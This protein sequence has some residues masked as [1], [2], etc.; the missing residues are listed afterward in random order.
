MSNFENLE[1]CIREK[2]VDFVRM[3]HGHAGQII[4]DGKYMKFRCPN[5][6]FHRNGDRKPSATI[7]LTHPETY[8]CFVC[9]DAGN[10]FQL[11]NK[12]NNAP[13]L[14]KEFIISNV[15]NLAQSF[16]MQPVAI[17]MSE[18]DIERAEM[19]SCMKVI[20][21][22]MSDSQFNE[23]KYAQLNG[24]TIETCLSLCI[25]TFKWDD[26]QKEMKARAP[27]EWVKQDL[28]R[29][30]G[31]H[32]Y[33]FGPR[34]IT[35]L[36][37]DDHNRP[38][39]L[40]ARD[41][42]Y[43]N[44]YESLG[45]SAYTEGQ[46]KDMEL[47]GRSPAKWHNSRSTIIYH[48]KDLLY[49]FNWTRRSPMNKMYVF[50]GYWDFA[51]AYQEGVDHCCAVCGTSL[52]EEHL[53]MLVENSFTKIV[54]AFDNDEPG[55][56]TARNIVKNYVKPGAG[57]S[58]S[59]LETPVTKYNEKE[60][61]DPDT[62]ILAHGTKSFMELPV[63]DAFEF[64]LNE[65][66][67]MGGDGIE[68]SKRLLPIICS[69]PDAVYQD[70]LL[71]SLANTCHVNIQALREDRARIMQSRSEEVRK[72][73]IE[74][75]T[76][77][78]RDFLRKA[79]ISLDSA[80]GTVDAMVNDMNNLI[81]SDKLAMLS[82]QQSYE[83]FTTWAEENPLR[84]EEPGWYTGYKLFDNALELIPKKGAWIS[85]PGA[86][87]HGKSAFLYC[88]ITA[89]CK[90]ND[91]SNITIMLLSLDDSSEICFWKIVAIL[92]GVKIRDVK[93]EYMLEEGEMLSKIRLAK[94][95]VASWIQNRI[96]VIKDASIG[97]S[98]QN[99]RQWVE[100]FQREEPNRCPILFLDNFHCFECGDRAEW[101]AASKML[102][103]MKTTHDMTFIST[104]EVPKG[105]MDFANPEYFLNMD[106]VAES[107][108]MVFD[109]SAVMTVN[110][111][112]AAKPD[113]TKVK[114]RW[115]RNG[116]ILPLVR[117]VFAKNKLSSFKSSLWFKFDPA[118]GLYSPI[119]IRAHMATIESQKA[120]GMT[121]R[122]GHAF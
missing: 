54:L 14:G 118:A 53:G 26:V 37:F 109:A 100:V 114:Y 80:K 72:K 41:M 69:Y 38:V 78:S 30:L 5:A 20:R 4:E 59:I 7:T 51:I 64:Q 119:D 3:N 48:K 21:E 84:T 33:M 71:Q 49:G 47:R 91:T 120:H 15:N 36:I 12:W 95:L 77:C 117:L 29:S 90:R 81:I 43:D 88:L 23:T 98:P 87:N 74:M 11:N 19:Y 73:A 112:W 92:A 50:E 60:D 94:E 31:I 46:I 10:I 32:K 97:N 45:I 83:K 25:G 6:S 105:H 86:P 106:A 40:A 61:G 113:K 28:M 39:S 79:E 103:G 96:L 42:Q 66:M 108:K 52:T 76:R 24:V 16:G 111:E 55:K 121:G 70:S 9:N 58:I 102:H 65:E 104:M 93:N 2:L 107:G 110:S 116:E 57:F 1:S 27:E 62:Y 34:L 68:M 85:I 18:E 89:L 115:Y 17:E 8:H 13:L 122:D 82:S 22:I 101:I 67:Q 35:V 99:M 44:N 75:M 63:L 56:E